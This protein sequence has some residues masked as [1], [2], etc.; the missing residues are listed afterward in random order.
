M[1]LSTYPPEPIALCSVM[2]EVRGF[3]IVWLLLL[4]QQT[5]MLGLNAH[6]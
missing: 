4:G 1:A 5:D 3:W 2:H 6:V